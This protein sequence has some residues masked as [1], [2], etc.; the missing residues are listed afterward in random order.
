MR[1]GAVNESL[2]TGEIEVRANQIRI[3]SESETPPFPI[4]A[5][6]PD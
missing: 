4:E 5:E 2:K 1:E 3:L 6:Q